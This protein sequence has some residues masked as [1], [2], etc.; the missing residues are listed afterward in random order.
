MAADLVAAGGVGGVAGLDL[1]GAS[2]V[3]EPE[4]MRGLLVREA[5]DAVAALVD[6]GVMVLGSD[7]QCER[8]KRDREFHRVL[9][10]SECFE[11]AGL[12]AFWGACE[13][14]VPIGEQ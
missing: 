6:A 2:V 7:G 8:D 1:D 9:L 4:M 12:R 13:T 10:V 14:L 11:Q 3:V 5:H